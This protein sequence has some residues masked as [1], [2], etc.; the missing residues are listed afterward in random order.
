MTSSTGADQPVPLA[1]VAAGFLAQRDLRSRSITVYGQTLA[2]L[3]AYAGADTPI[4]QL[5]EAELQAF[6]DAYYADAAPATWNL[7]PGGAAVLFRLRPPP[8]R[9]RR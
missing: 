7:K 6:M 2:R 3:A 5:G 9:N 4:D 1:A 8:A